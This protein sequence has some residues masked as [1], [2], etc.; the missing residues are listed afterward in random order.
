M[1][2]KQKLD[3]QKVGLNLYRLIDESNYTY[4]Y[5]AEFLM[6][7]SP[8]VIYEWTKGTKMPTIENLMNLANLF[9]VR[10]EDILS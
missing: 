9:D 5:V 4:E 10:I 8:R 7:S 1:N 2:Y 3:K 6:F